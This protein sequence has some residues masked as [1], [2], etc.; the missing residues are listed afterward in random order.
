[1]QYSTKNMDRRVLVPFKT[2]LWDSEPG[3]Q[4][5]DNVL[6]YPHIS[7]VSTVAKTGSRTVTSRI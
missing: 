4:G 1:M 3:T 5:N 7:T 6:I 2:Q